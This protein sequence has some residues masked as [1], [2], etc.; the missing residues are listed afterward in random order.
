[1]CYPEATTAKKRKMIMDQK[2]CICMY[3]LFNTRG[4]V[5]GLRK[6]LLFF[7]AFAMT[8]A[9]FGTALAA[10]ADAASYKVKAWKG[11]SYNYYVYQGSLPQHYEPTF[12]RYDNDVYK[13]GN[14]K[15]SFYIPWDNADAAKA[16][17]FC[18]YQINK[19]GNSVSSG[20]YYTPLSD[21]EY[22]YYV[23]KVDGWNCE[24]ESLDKL[25]RQSPFTN[26][27]GQKLYLEY[28]GRGNVISSRWSDITGSY[29]CS[30]AGYFP[31]VD[32]TI[33]FRFVDPNGYS[34]RAYTTV[35]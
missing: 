35:G 3:A 23:F 18:R 6:G 4:R 1:M 2:G 8:V 21:G 29:D 31:G 13:S 32:A 16:E 7:L 11:G 19:A 10:P 9:V 22:M 17:A 24:R 27:N 15:F 30:A 33:G 5:S 20:W 14:M 28:I 12:F 26:P 34:T 25:L